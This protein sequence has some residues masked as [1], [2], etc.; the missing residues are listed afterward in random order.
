MIVGV[1]GINVLISFFSLPSS[2]KG[3]EIE[4]LEANF[5]VF[6]LSLGRFT[7][8]DFGAWDTLTTGLRPDL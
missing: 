6:T 8:C 7:G 5:Q 4:N 3:G 1:K 2:I